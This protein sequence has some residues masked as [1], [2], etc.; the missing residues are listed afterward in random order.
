MKQLLVRKNLDISMPYTV[1]TRGY[2]GLTY[3]RVGGRDK[4]NGKSTPCILFNGF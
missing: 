2:R 4:F 1:P 3:R